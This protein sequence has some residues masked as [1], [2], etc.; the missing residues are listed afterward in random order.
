MAFGAA[1]AVHAQ[2]WGGGHLHPELLGAFH[3]P[4]STVLLSDASI[5]TIGAE[6]PKLAR[7]SPD[8]AE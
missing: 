3:L 1:G 8:L 6:G 7:F 4:Q 5:A 2:W